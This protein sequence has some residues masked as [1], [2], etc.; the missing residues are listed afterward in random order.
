MFVLIIPDSS[1]FA[2]SAASLRRCIAVLSFRR[3]MPFSFLKVSTIQFIIFSSKS[4]PPSRLLPAVA[5]TSNTPSEISS[6]ETSNVP[7]PRS[8]IR[9]FWSSS[10]SSP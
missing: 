2:F 6:S 10:L 1:I 8:K 9:I 7:P 4:S 5:S 3:S